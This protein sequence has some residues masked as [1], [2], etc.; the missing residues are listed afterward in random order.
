MTH[1]LNPFPAHAGINRP[2]SFRARSWRTVPRTRGDQPAG[3][4]EYDSQ[5]DRSPH[6]RGSTGSR[7]HAR[8]HRE[9]FPAH[10]GINRAPRFSELL[11]TA[12]PRTR[13][14]Q[15]MTLVDQINALDRSPHTRGSTAAD[16]G[17]TGRMA[18]FPAHAGINRSCRRPCRP[19]S[20]VPRTRGDQ[21][22]RYIRPIWGHYRSPHTRGSTGRDHPCDAGRRPFPAH[23][24]INRRCRRS[25]GC[26]WTVPRTRGDQPRFSGVLSPAGNRSPHTRGS[27]DDRPHRDLCRG[28]FPAHA[29]I[30]RRPV[31]RRRPAPPVPRTRG[32]PKFDSKS[33]K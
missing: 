25:R 33:S 9:P 27:T 19:S 16:R 23:A 15:P 12:V 20:A 7:R 21:P 11:R 24:G 13:G 28:P 2:L 29:G 17:G 4:M 8:S 14:D 22:R 26:G 1:M 32:D 6:T 10:A 3:P 5:M 30:N 18:P 31:P